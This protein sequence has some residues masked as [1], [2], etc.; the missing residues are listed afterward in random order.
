MCN[1]LLAA[2]MA[3]GSSWAREQT[4][5]AVQPVPL[6][7]SNI[8]YLTRRATMERPIILILGLNYSCKVIKPM[9][10]NKEEY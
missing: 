3:C 6:A 8:R 4:C 5:A 9:L 2:L 7:G 1:C 10:C